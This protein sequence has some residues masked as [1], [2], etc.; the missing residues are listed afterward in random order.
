MKSC[1]FLGIHSEKQISIEI[2][3]MKFIDLFQYVNE[4]LENSIKEMKNSNHNFDQE[5]YFH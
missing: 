4:L 2:D 3:N 1:N 5:N